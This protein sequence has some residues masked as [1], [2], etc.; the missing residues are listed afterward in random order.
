MPIMSFPE[1][2]T[3]P[4]LR[5]QVLDLHQE[6]WPSPGPAAPADQPTHDPA[7]TPLSLLL[8][9]GDQVL[10]AL[11]I[12][13]KTIDHAGRRYRAAGLSTVV[14]R[15]AARG[16]G[17]G[18]RLVAHARSVMAQTGTDVG[19]FT[20]DRPLQG[21]Y[22]RAGWSLVPGAVLLGGTPED[23]LRS[24]EAGF[25]K[26]VMAGF[27]SAAGQ[28]GQGSFAHSEIALYPGPIDRLW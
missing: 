21:F 24:D 18:A 23:P 6:A 1:A 13:H 10:A 15:Q 17:H 8:V 26:V 25:D 7:L 9:D 3:P 4:P 28:Q 12:L 11:D 14:T 16:Q 22:E 20:C 19:L 2:D 27:L 5:T